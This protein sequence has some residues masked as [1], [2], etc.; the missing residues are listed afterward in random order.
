M[1]ANQFVKC[2]L[3]GYDACYAALAQDVKGMWLTF[4]QKAHTLIRKENVSWFIGKNMPPN[5]P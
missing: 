1:K 5:W 4:D 3:T 2:G